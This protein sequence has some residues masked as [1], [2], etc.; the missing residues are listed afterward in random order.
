MWIVWFKSCCV[1]HPGICKFLKQDFKEAFDLFN[2]QVIPE[3]VTS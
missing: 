2:E 3:L 1:N